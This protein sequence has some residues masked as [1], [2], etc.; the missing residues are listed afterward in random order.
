MDQNSII[1]IIGR[2]SIINNHL[3]ISSKFGVACKTA[4]NHH[5]FPIPF[6]SNSITA[7]YLSFLLFFPFECFESK[8]F[9]ESH[10]DLFGGAIANLSLSSSLNR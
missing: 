5:S 2:I 10:E 7:A 9:S 6:R 8:S 1:M 3:K 4:N